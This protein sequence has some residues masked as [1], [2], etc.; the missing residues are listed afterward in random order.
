[1]ENMKLSAP[2]MTFVNKIRELFLADKEVKILYDDEMKNVKLYVADARKA[3][4]L[5]Q[6]MPKEKAFGNIK[7]TIDVVPANEGEKSKVDL[8]REAFRGNGAVAGIH[9]VETPFGKTAYVIFEREV[10]QFFNDQMDDINGN[11]NTLYQEIAK[12]VFEDHDGIFFCTE[13]IPY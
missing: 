5:E 3:E 9:E 7:L 11:L 12:D 1:M 8:F 6:L 13:A 4:A 10:V 2:W